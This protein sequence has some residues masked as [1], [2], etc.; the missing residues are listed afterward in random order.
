MC[1]RDSPRS[2]R[3]SWCLLS[4]PLRIPDRSSQHGTAARITRPAPHV[5][6]GATHSS[7]ISV[8]LAHGLQV[9]SDV[10][11][12][13]DYRPGR[14]EDQRAVEI[15]GLR[16]ETTGPD[17][18]GIAACSASRTLIQKTQIQSNAYRSSN[19]RAGIRIFEASRSYNWRADQ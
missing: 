17:Q 19:D 8:P 14:R 4:R 10:T 6:M 5:S 18:V 13:S 7:S 2:G 12:T 16:A 3:G 15:Q 1:I 11:A 9:I